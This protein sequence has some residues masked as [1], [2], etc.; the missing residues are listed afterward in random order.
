MFTGIIETVGTIKKLTRKGPR[1]FL[2]IEAVSFFKDT[3]PGES[4]AVNGTC[5]TIINTADSSFTAEISPETMARTSFKYAGPGE[6]VNLEKALKLDANLSGHVVTG[7]IDGVGKILWKRKIQDNTVYNIKVPSECIQYIVTKGSVAID[8]ISLTVNKIRD[9]QLSV[10]ILPYT[11]HN[12]NLK[13]KKSGS[14]VNIETDIL[15]KYVERFLK[16]SALDTSITSEKLREY[17]FR[18]RR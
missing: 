17:G 15:G 13:Y 14:L 10:S 6:K 8:G 12:S 18:I 11:E 1:Y 7:H 2:K 5:L 4:I 3:K 9:S 16:V